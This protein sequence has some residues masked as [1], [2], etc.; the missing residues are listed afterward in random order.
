MFSQERR[1]LR[2]EY[3]QYVWLTFLRLGTL[4]QVCHDVGASQGVVDHQIGAGKILGH[5]VI[6]C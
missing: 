5:G 3:P 1:R 6:S 4:P 2:F